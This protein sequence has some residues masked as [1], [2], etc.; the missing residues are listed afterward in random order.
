MLGSTDSN[1]AREGG[2]GWHAG[3]PHHG[4][5]GA[6]QP[7]APPPR[8]PRPARQAHH[9]VQRG[10][11]SSGSGLGAAAPRC[12]ARQFPGQ[13]G[14]QHALSPGQQL[15]HIARAELARHARR[16]RRLRGAR[17]GRGVQQRLGHLSRAGRRQGRSNEVSGVL[18]R[19]GEPP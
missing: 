17:L 10:V 8:R 7:P 19:G 9:A 5:A 13:P 6:A 12:G 15:S 3:A 16:R 4:T 1:L 18:A 11:Q 2:P 14:G